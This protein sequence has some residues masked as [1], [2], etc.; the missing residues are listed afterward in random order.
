MSDSKIKGKAMP[1]QAGKKANDNKLA[2][3]A[4]STLEFQAGWVTHDFQPHF[5]FKVMSKF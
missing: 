4:G 1:P 3:Q 2:H 5:Y